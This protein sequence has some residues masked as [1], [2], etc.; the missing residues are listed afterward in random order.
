MDYPPSL[1]QAS[2]PREL[3]VLFCVV[4]T[5]SEHSVHRLCVNQG[6]LAFK[7]LT[8][9]LFPPELCNR[10]DFEWAG[11]AWMQN[12][13]LDEACELQFPT[14]S[15][16]LKLS[17]IPWSFSLHRCNVGRG[18]RFHSCKARRLDGGNEPPFTYLPPSQREAVRTS[19]NGW[20]ND[21]GGD[22]NDTIWTFPRS[23]SSRTNSF[24]RTPTD[25][26]VTR[27]NQPTLL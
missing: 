27:W 23:V 2:W 19:G 21:Y 6:T 12:V 13:F 26:G 3:G 24:R 20:F 17:V 10:I 15:S 11:R 1:S 16:L 9:S 5:N 18:Y 14:S 4:W 25:R 22:H 8:G 7:F